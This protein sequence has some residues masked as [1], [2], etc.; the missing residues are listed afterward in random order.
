MNNII[1]LL[2]YG[3][4]TLGLLALATSH[5]VGRISCRGSAIRNQKYLSQTLAA[6]A[7]DLGTR[8][9]IQARS[10]QPGADILASFQSFQA[11][12]A[13]DEQIMHW[14]TRQAIARRFPFT[15]AELRA[16]AAASN[17]PLRKIPYGVSAFDSTAPTAAALDVIARQPS[18]TLRLGPR[19]NRR[20]RCRCDRPGLR[21]RNASLEY[22]SIHWNV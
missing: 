1:P 15:I 2:F 3:F 20:R 19:R 22:P 13:T 4:V 9:P 12:R 11:C 21:W 14:R 17:A 7:H 16:V 8:R 18:V 10:R 6:T 5:V